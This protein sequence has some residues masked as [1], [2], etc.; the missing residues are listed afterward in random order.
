MNTIK[1]YKEENGFDVVATQNQGGGT[2]SAMVF[3]FAT[4]DAANKFVE[5]FLKTMEI[6]G[7]SWWINPRPPLQTPD[8]LHTRSA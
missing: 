3:E 4:E 8:T 2:K 6:A 5:S 7:E 1:I